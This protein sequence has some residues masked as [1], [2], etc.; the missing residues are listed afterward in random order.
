[1][2]L[3]PEILVTQPLAVLATAAII[4]LGKSIVAF[5]IVRAFGHPNRTAL[6]ISASLAQVGE[7]SFILAGLG[8]ALKIL[9]EEGRDLVLAGSIISILLNP[10]LF[11]LLDRWK[12]GTDVDKGGDPTPTLVDLK[13][14]ELSGHAIIVGYGRV[15]SFAGEALIDAGIPIVVTEEN[16]KILAGLRARKIAVVPGNAV[17]DEVMNAANLAGARWL[18]VAIP[19]AFEVS[20]I[21]R[22]ATEGA[23][24]AF[25]SRGNLAEWRRRV[26]E[27]GSSIVN[28]SARIGGC[29]EFALIVIGNILFASITPAIRSDIWWRSSHRWG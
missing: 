8:V 10:L 3:D 5:A 18:L 9:P 23:T 22:H 1:M 25:T 28:A 24:H 19:E 4:I 21:V 29:T 11:V 16:Q 6:T 27:G 26:L 2:L 14:I 20:Q 12:L 15:G 7:F 13:S 17:H